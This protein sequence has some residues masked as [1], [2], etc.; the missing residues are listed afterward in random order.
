MFLDKDRLL[1]NTVFTLFWVWC[2]YGFISE[3]IVPALLSIES[4]AL[5]LVDMALLFIGIIVLKDKRDIIFVFSFLV[6]GYYI[7]C[8][9]NHNSL[10]YFINGLRDFIYIIA[11]I[12]IIRYLYNSRLKEEFVQKFDKH[13]LIFLVV[14]A[15]CIT[16][17]FVK[18]GANDHGGGSMGNGY[19]GIVSMMIYLISFYLMRKRIDPN[20][21]VGSL[22]ANKW[23]L[24]L[25]MPTF[26]NET[27]ISFIFFAL[28]FILLMPIDKKSLVKYLIMIPL[29]LILI[30]GVF[31]V[32]LSATGNKDDITNIDYYI[33]EYLIASEDNDILLWAEYLYDHGEIEADG[34][35]D[36]P[37][38]T[39]YLL[40]P[41]INEEYPGHDITGYGIGQFKGGTSI[42]YSKFYKDNEWMLRGSMPYGYHAYIQIGLFA[43]LFF[44]WF[45]MRVYSFRKKEN[46]SDI[47]I[48]VYIWL[49][50]VLVLFYNDFF[51]YSFIILPTIYIMS[52]ALRGDYMKPY[53]IEK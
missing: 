13:L 47:S 38:F 46:P 22:I 23:L 36:V 7:T 5:T 11:I 40:I 44:V 34:S 14:Q 51:R 24:I 31:S 30:S 39:K 26:L 8:V 32:Y 52:Q 10:L 41:E 25:L 49:L 42:E 9:H 33:D 35:A 12:P 18:Y 48:Q 4:M 19:S 17:Q 2:S 6:V 20:N 27:K 29:L 16:F 1:M 37:R 50:V 45:W 15:I 28:Y 3:E 43:I 21:Y 53:E